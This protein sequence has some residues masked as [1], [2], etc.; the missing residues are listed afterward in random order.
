[1]TANSSGQQLHPK[2]FV[3]LTLNII[4]AKNFYLILMSW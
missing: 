4:W 3:L 2:F 1:M